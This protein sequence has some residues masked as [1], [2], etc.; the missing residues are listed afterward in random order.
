MTGLWLRLRV[1]FPFPESY[2][3]EGSQETNTPYH[4]HHNHH[5]ETKGRMWWPMR[6]TPSRW[7]HRASTTTTTTTTTTRCCR[8]ALNQKFGSGGGAAVVQHR[9]Q[10]GSCGSGPGDRNNSDNNSYLWDTRAVVVVVV[11][12]QQSR[13]DFFSAAG[14]RSS[15]SCSSIIVSSTMGSLLPPTRLFSTASIWLSTTVRQ[16]FKIVD[17]P[18]VTA[19]SRLPAVISRWWKPAVVRFLD[20][21]RRR[22]GRIMM[23]RQ[24]RTFHTSRHVA[25]LSDFRDSVP[26]SQRAVEPVGR[27]WSAKELRRKSY[28]DLHKLW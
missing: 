5:H 25:A 15:S 12:Q 24:Q 8:P 19:V 18:A 13:Y 26:R 27:P 14:L 23:V 10:L 28:D 9:F 20:T 6:T 7:Y 21:D 1:G 3:T 16:I 4:C 2:G 22:P 17:Y 11:G